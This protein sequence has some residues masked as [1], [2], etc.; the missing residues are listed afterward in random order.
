MIEIFPSPASDAMREILPAHHKMW[1]VRGVVLDLHEVERPTENPEKQNPGGRLRDTVLQ[2]GDIDNP[3]DGYDVRIEGVHHQVEPNDI[4]SLLGHEPLEAQRISHPRL[5]INHCTGEFQRAYPIATRLTYG[6]VPAIEYKYWLAAK[7]R[8]NVKEKRRN[9]WMLAGAIML[10]ATLLLGMG[11][12]LIALFVGGFLFLAS[13][14]LLIGL[15]LGFAFMR[16]MLGQPRFSHENKVPPP[17]LIANC[18][19]YIN[20]TR[21][22]LTALYETLAH[23]LHEWVRDN[24]DTENE[25]VPVARG[26]HTVGIL[27]KVNAPPAITTHNEPSVPV[28]T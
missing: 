9:F 20:H 14:P 11:N 1:W 13:L 17:L 15:A 26:I 6:V 21:T 7:T 25:W 3:N 28:A 18:Q 19:E 16:F 2:V 12:P 27:S 23:R 22:D 5:Y 24:P 10:G 8:A 4:I